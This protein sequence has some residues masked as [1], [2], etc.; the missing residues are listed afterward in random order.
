MTTPGQNNPARAARRQPGSRRNQHFMAPAP[1]EAPPGRTACADLTQALQAR[2]KAC[3]V[4]APEHPAGLVVIT[5]TEESLHSMWLARVGGWCYYYDPALLR[6]ISRT[7]IRGRSLSDPQI[8]YLKHLKNLG[9]DL[10]D[11]FLLFSVSHRVPQLIQSL[12]KMVGQ[13]RD[14]V[15]LSEF[16]MASQQ[17]RKLVRLLPMS[18]KIQWPELRVDPVEKRR[19]L[20]QRLA[21][22][23][24]LLARKDL[25]AHDFHQVKKDLRLVHSVYFCLH[26]EPA[27]SSAAGLAFSATKKIIKLMHHVLLEE[28][29][30]RQLKYRATVITLPEEFRHHVLLLLAKIRVT[31]RPARRVPMP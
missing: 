6:A 21:G 7:L 19:F 15:R 8:E 28:K 22:M 4:L 2:W 11:F 12:V 25:T 27:R 31:G 16:R 18:G 9:D 5:L 26:P 10:R 30:K 14:Q 20:A 1:P 29:Y 24:Q 23:K 13:L 17:A 3:R